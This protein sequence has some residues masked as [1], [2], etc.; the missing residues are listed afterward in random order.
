MLVWSGVAFM[1]RKL[2]LSDRPPPPQPTAKKTP[3]N[4]NKATA[5]VDLVNMR[6]LE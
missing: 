1:I 2:V 6:L 3:H 4:A 5:L